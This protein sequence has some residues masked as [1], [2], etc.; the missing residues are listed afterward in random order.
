MGYKGKHFTQPT[1]KANNNNKKRK[2]MG[3]TRSDYSFSK[4]SMKQHLH[5]QHILFE[6]HLTHTHTH[7]GKCVYI[8]YS[9][10]FSVKGDA[11][12]TKHNIEFNNFEKLCKQTK[13][14]A[15]FYIGYCI[16]LYMP[17]AFFSLEK[18]TISYVGFFRFI[19]IFFS[20][21]F[22]ILF[23]FLLYR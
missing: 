10:P 20:F 22:L 16:W 13:I 19:Y 11:L 3:W 8:Y 1:E 18:R 4:R 23:F 7:N 6:S 21:L 5:I 12:L 2:K 14:V 15:W 17:L 9:Q